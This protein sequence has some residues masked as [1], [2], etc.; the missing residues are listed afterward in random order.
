[1]S[2]AKSDAQERDTVMSK[3][4]G[5]RKARIVAWGV[6]LGLYFYALAFVVAGV[7]LR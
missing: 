1:M 6:G 7:V 5:N 4:M 3:V 2:D